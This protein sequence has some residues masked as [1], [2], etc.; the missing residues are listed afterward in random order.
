MRHLA[1]FLALA[2]AAS[3][4]ALAANPPARSGPTKPHQ[5][6]STGADYVSPPAL[7]YSFYLDARTLPVVPAW[8]PG[9]PIREFP[10]QFH[11]EE[12]LQNHRPQPANAPEADPLV[13]IQRA[14]T[15]RSTRDF[16]TP[17]VNQE[18]QPF[19][20]SQPP[21][22]G[23]DVGGGF[24]IQ[25]YN[26][27]G[28]SQYT[29][30]N[31]AD[32]SVAAGPFNMDNLA[33]GGPCADGYCDGIVLFDQLA[34]RWLLTEFSNV[35]NNLCV[36]I[37]AD[38]NPVTTTWTR[39]VF[40]TPGFPDY[41]KYGVWPNAYYI[42]ANQGPAVYAID[43]NAMLA[44]NP[45]TLQRKGVP[46][47]GGLGFQ[48]VVPATVYGATPPAA[49]APG[50]FV[51]DN[52]DERNS[53]SSNDPNHDFI[54]LFTMHV[55]FVTPTNTTLT[56]PIRIEES[57]FDSEFNVTSGFGAIHQ[58]GTSQTLDPLLE[59]MMFP[60]HYRNFGD[61]EVLVGNHVTQVQSGNIAGIRWI[62]LRR[63][64]G[65]TDW[66]LYQ[67]G[68][69]S[70][71]DADGIISRW[72]G[73]VGM[74]QAGNIALGYSVARANPAVY[75][76]LRYVGRQDSDPLGVMTTPETS[77][78]EGG[79][80]QSGFGGDRWGDY[81]QMGVDPD[82]G[83][84]FWFT[85]EYEPAG[86][87][88][89]TR[90]GS[91]RFDSC[92]TTP[93][94][95]MTGTNLDQSVCA[96]S[97]APTALQPVDIEITA[98]NGF[99]TPV[100]M[101]LDSPPAGFAGTFTPNPVTPPGTTTADVTVT[102][103]APPGDNSLTLHASAGG[104]ERD[105]TLGVTVAT[106]APV[107]VTLQLPPD[108]ASNVSSQPIFTWAAAEQVEN[109]L[110]EVATD[111]AFS[112]VILSQTVP[113]GTTTFQPTA[114]LPTNTQLFW[115]VSAANIC[116][117]AGPSAVFSFTTQSAPGDCSTGT[118]TVTLFSDDVENG[119]NGWTHDAAAG[120]DTWTI[121][122]DQPNSPTHSWFVVDTDGL[123][124]QRLTSP[125]IDLPADLGG[126]T[127]QFQ[128]QRDIENDGTD[129]C[130]DGGIL[131]VA[132]DGGAF[133]QVPDSA[134]VTDPYTGPVS[135]QY[136]NPIANQLAWC[137][138]QPYTQSIVDA[139]AYAGH[140]VQFRFRMASDSSVGHE[141]WYID[142]ISMKGCSSGPADRIFASGFDGP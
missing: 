49:D 80:S 45:A 23:G 8:K 89:S 87:S 57:E 9:D 122:T 66:T 64:T 114:A 48:M 36:Y 118:D 42:G 85:G 40:T 110:I 58:P 34:Q 71:A 38:S 91:F 74:D 59:V 56:G 11:G 24:Y 99:N 16:T 69:W 76:G 25:N 29:I 28:G 102:N 14:F 32:G 126:L 130:Y 37:S 2:V 121:N 94:Y 33:T 15:P 131:E 6:V 138:Q 101:S 128:N 88:W 27:S 120:T 47:L 53:P 132:V 61:H 18:G 93:T 116:G 140:S 41:P 22:P 1:T 142:D 106:V 141:G 83:C 136:S 21:D 55:D 86:G 112:N 98:R 50:I 127:F 7:P 5:L 65:D 82:D 139:S 84:T 77:L 109:Y 60:F 30:Y 31:V 135:D 12:A 117:D 70:P 79:S 95:T 72:M 39:Y 52:D 13:A 119:D 111:S 17:L 81:F 103:A 97:S 137:G 125:V 123:S 10:R 104:I 96:M 105:L 124:D 43:R 44:G 67:E 3:A 90:I 46:G 54:E 19:D 134:L 100:V 75:P 26:G 35:G 68:T 20:G 62:E 108:G 63:N 113:G 107:A 78:V 115:R 133:T 129:A 51:R 73:A 4:P 92:G